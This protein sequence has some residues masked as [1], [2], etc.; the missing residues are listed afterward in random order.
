MRG[1]PTKLAATAACCASLALSL[2]GAGAA[3]ASD[4]PLTT[5]TAQ[6]RAATPAEIQWARDHFNPPPPYFASQCRTHR[7]I[8]SSFEC[9]GRAYLVQSRHGQSLFPTQVR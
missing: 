2:L 5:D 6:F 1:Y 7:A 3:H 4:G 8:R 9:N